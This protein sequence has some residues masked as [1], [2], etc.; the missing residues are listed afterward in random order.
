MQQ[1]QPTPASATPVARFLS[2]IKTD[3]RNRAQAPVISSLLRRL[4]WTGAFV[5]R[6]ASRCLLFVA[7]R[8]LALGT[9]NH[10]IDAILACRLIEFLC[11]CSPHSRRL[12]CD[13]RTK[14][15]SCYMAWR[16]LL[17]M[18]LVRWWLG[19]ATSSCANKSLFLPFGDTQRFITCVE[20]LN[21]KQNNMTWSPTCSSLLRLR[22]F[23]VIFPVLWLRR[24]VIMD[25]Y[26]SLMF[27]WRTEILFI[28]RS[29][30]LLKWSGFCPSY[31]Y[32]MCYVCDIVTLCM[33]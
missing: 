31:M 27:M 8:S 23:V 25:G 11:R 21:N 3:H 17:T 33:S 26:C 5:I 10:E 20:R 30:R 24:L 14:Y 1:Q 18:S 28:D 9:A 29:N 16:I 13:T 2:L 12:T 7:V 15:Y 6:S 4:S 19:N 32:S 22:S